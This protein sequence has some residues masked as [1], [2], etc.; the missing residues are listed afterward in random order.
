VD[1]LLGDEEAV[2]VL[3]EVIV[4]FFFPS[5]SPSPSVVSSKATV[6]DVPAVGNNPPPTTPT[7]L[8]LLPLLS[9]SSLPPIMVDTN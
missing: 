7:V 6:E 3:V 5:L 2:V 9:P 1:G 8:P 4:V